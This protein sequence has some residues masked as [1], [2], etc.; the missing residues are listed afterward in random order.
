MTLP[1]VGYLVSHHYIGDNI[2][3]FHFKYESIGVKI[4]MVASVTIPS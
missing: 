4:A 3:R 1:Q 2:Q